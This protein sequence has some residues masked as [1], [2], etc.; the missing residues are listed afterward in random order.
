MFTEAL[1]EPEALIE[2]FGDE[3]NV[4]PPRVEPRSPLDEK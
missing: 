1:I 2:E 3:N 4:S